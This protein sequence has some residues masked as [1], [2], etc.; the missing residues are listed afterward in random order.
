MMRGI[1]FRAKISKHGAN[2]TNMPREISNA[3]SKMVASS[4]LSFLDSIMD[5]VMKAMVSR[6]YSRRWFSAMI[7]IA[8]WND[9]RPVKKQSNSTGRCARKF[10]RMFAICVKPGLTS[11]MPKSVFTITSFSARCS[12]AARARRNTTKRLDELAD[13]HGI[14][15]DEAVAE[16][17]RESV[18]AEETPT[19]ENPFGRFF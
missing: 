12:C 6:S 16:V 3:Q 13:A 15:F 9:V 1:Q 17:C 14:D 5:T 4:R 2:G 11:L 19:I 18:G 7:M 8:G 10:S